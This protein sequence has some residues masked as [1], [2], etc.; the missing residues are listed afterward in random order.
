MEYSAGFPSSFA[1]GYRVHDYLVEAARLQRMGVADRSKCLISMARDN[2]LYPK[3]FILCPILLKAKDG[4]RFPHPSLGEE[5]YLGH[6]S[7]VD[8]PTSPITLYENVPILVMRC[9]VVNGNVFPARY[10]VEECLSN[11][12]WRTDPIIVDTPA[13]VSK[14]IDSFLATMPDISG[15]DISWLKRQGALGE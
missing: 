15:K 7:E 11:C 9:S 12:F 8:W 6:S 4:S 1:D 10:Y 13:E 5:V 3:V 14:A 2:A